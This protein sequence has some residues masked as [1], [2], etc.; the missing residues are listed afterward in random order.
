MQ[1]VEPLEVEIGTVHHIES[2]GFW[3][4]QIQNVDIVHLAVAD[5][6]ESWNGASQIEK[7]M[8]F[9]RSFCFAKLGPRKQLQTQIDCGG[10]QCIDC[11]R[12]VDGQR[13]VAI[14]PAGNTD[15]RLRKFEID[16]PVSGFVGVGYSTATGL[17]ANAQV[18]E[19]CGL[20]RQASMSRILSL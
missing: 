18:I 13:F 11:F 16:S 17:A 10:I 9:H 2:T 14:K 5:M 1:A 7:S 20:G 3:H 19:F 4:E 6:N 15:K 12:K 8:Q